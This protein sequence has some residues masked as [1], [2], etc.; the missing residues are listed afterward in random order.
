M[1]TSEMFAPN[2]SQRKRM[3]LTQSRAQSLAD[4][5]V[6]LTYNGPLNRRGY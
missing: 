4:A 6:G 1:A 2:V 5:D 3:I